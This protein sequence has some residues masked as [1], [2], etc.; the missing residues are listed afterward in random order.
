MLLDYID[1]NVLSVIKDK[2]EDG[3]LALAAASLVILDFVLGAVALYD[4]AINT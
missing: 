3:T 2:R 4:Y 1:P